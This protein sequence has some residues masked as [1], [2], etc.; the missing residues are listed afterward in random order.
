MNKF[1]KLYPDTAI[2]LCSSSKF[3]WT[4]YSCTGNSVPFFVRVLSL[5]LKLVNN[6]MLLSCKP[7][8][9]HAGVADAYTQIRMV[10]VPFIQWLLIS[11]VINIYSCFIDVFLHLC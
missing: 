7:Q 8:L 10:P 11:C 6:S 4:P 9:W 1:Q 5:K 3:P 2:M